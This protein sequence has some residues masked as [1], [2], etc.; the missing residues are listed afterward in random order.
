MRMTVRA[1]LLGALFTTGACFAYRP[2]ALAPAPGAHVRIVF[3]SSIAVA[4]FQL[5]PDSTRHVYSGVLEASGT[6]EAAATDTVAL[7]LGELRT[8]AGAVPDVSG[9]VALLPSA[10]IARIEERRF[11]AGTTALA[12]IGAAALSLTA[13]LVLLIAAI[14]KGF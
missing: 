4:T 1:A 13:L 7:H 12:G 6:I 5:G 8:A 9:Q 3:T 10:Q 2:V 11:Q 14:T